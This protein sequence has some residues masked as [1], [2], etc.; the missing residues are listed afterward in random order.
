MSVNDFGIL[1]EITDVV[2]W[3]ADHKWWLIVRNYMKFSLQVRG[4]KNVEAQIT[5]ISIVKHC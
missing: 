3:R 4:L 1:N 2:E 5:K